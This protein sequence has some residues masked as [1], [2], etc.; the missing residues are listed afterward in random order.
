[1]MAVTSLSN[2][3]LETDSIRP[4]VFTLPFLISKLVVMSTDYHVKD[5]VRNIL[6]KSK[7]IYVAL[8]NIKGLSL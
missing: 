5:C 8:L 3:M 4:N 1:M 6:D 7:C 2:I